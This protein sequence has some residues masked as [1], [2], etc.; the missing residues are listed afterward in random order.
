MAICMKANRLDL[1]GKTMEDAIE[2]RA[3]Q[4]IVEELKVFGF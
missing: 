2:I 4:A 3:L 1:L